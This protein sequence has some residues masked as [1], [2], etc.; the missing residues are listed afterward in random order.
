MAKFTAKNLNSGFADTDAL[1]ENFSALET[2]S[3]TVLSRDGTVPNQMEAPVDMNSNRIINASNISTATLTV[4]GET[5]VVPSNPV[6]LPPDPQL[7]LDILQGKIILEF[8][9]VADMVADTA[10]VVGDIIQ[11]AGRT[12]KGDSGDNLYEI[13]AAAT[14]TDDG[15]SFIDLFLHQAKALFPSGVVNFSQFGAI[16]DGDGV[17]GGTD[18]AAA[19]QAT[20]DYFIAV[21][22][23]LEGSNKV[24]RCDS[25]VTFLKSTNTPLDYVIQGKGT[26]LDFSGGGIT[27][28]KLLAVGGNSIGEI[29]EEGSFAIYDLNITG[30]ETATP[31]ASDT[32]IS[33]TVGLDIQ[34]AL[35]V[36]LENIRVKK[37]FIGFKT[38]FVFPL[39]ARDC[40][41]RLCYEGLET[42]GASND[43]VWINFEAPDVRFG[44][45]IRDTSANKTVGISFLSPRVEGA[46]VGFVISPVAGASVDRIRSIEIRDPYLA[47]I[48]FDFF[49][50][51][52]TFDSTDASVRG[53][54]TSPQVVGLTVKGGHWGFGAGW[55]ATSS[56]FAFNTTAGVRGLTVEAPFNDQTNA[57]IGGIKGGQITYTGNVGVDPTEYRT[58]RYDDDGNKVFT[59]DKNGQQFNVATFTDLDTTPDVTQ[60]NIF[61]TANTGATAF[62]TFDGLLSTIGKQYT[63]LIKDANTSINF[64]T[65]T[66]LLGDGLNRKL[67]NGDKIEITFDGTDHHCNVV[68]TGYN[69]TE[70]TIATG[71]ITVD[72]TQLMSY[73]VDTEADAA[74]DDLDTIN[75]GTIEDRVVLRADD[76]A[77]TV[78]VKD[79]TG[80]I[81][82]AGS[83]D[84]SLDNILDRIELQFNGIQWV[85]LGR[86]SNG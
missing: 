57:V 39:S 27:S 8:D 56:A 34:F 53:T 24:H 50:V 5:L 49:R 37:T 29:A 11:T 45:V 35:N 72:S 82:L 86:T 64:K 16:G 84:F 23:T 59:L 83:V 60:G 13:V 47:G 51:G 66:N 22:G 48:A 36:V 14:G 31:A 2:F 21:G 10:L 6:T 78:V 54:N 76:N 28:G 79:G 74:S 15:G 38:E 80:N 70:L 30:P 68:P 26:T 58:V 71:A 69:S 43:Q 17:G 3:D 7:Y 4:N 33:S 61:Q 67:N 77:R 81:E 1:N 32:P 73:N 25:I 44:V 62:T 52:L 19:I 40:I 41:A 85:E 20:L 65:G 46:E 12:S 42:G 63:I 18:D 9:T 75:G 55:T